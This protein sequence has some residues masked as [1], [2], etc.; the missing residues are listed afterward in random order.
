MVVVNATREIGEATPE[1]LWLPWL[2]EL[3]PPTPA[4][5]ADFATPRGDG[6]LVVVAPHPDDEVLACGGLLARRAAGATAI[7]VIGVTDGDASHP[8]SRRWSRRALAE[9]RR[10]ERLAGLASL[11]L[12]AAAVLTLGVPD[13][14]VTQHHDAVTT[15]I[16]AAL[17]PDD[18]VIGTW[19]LDG[20]PDHD[21]SGAAAAR[22]CAAVG[23]RFIEAPV[24]MW[25]WAAPGDARV[26]W[27][28]LVRLPLS[29]DEVGA[30]HA[31]I[32]AHATQ[33]EARG[34]AD[35]PVLDAAILARAARA[36]EYF[37]V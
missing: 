25:H 21:A 3:A 24:W 4:R 14:G 13:G 18:V 16:A 28:R 30:K 31:A 33:L 15:A 34:G 7:V 8:H 6:R 5:D 37:F 19:R 29:A 20:H 22:A 32:A 2:A 12:G 23:C 36:S 35:G 11:G 26:P 9:A 10:R 27:Q 17:R 1:A